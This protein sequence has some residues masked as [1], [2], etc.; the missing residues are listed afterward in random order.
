MKLLQ[1][2]LLLLAFFL[3]FGVHGFGQ[4]G[5]TAIH[6][7][8]SSTAS[9]STYTA[10]GA[11]NSPLAG[12]SYN[13]RY[14]SSSG[15][16]DNQL[17]LLSI[18]AASKAYRYESIPVVVNFRRVN[19]PGFTGVRDLM[20]YFGALDGSTLNLKAPYEDNMITAFE[21]NT[22]MLRGS[23]NLFA[24]AVDGNGNINNIERL[25]VVV[26]AGV[27]MTSASGQG[28]ALMERGALN[29][30]DAFVVGVITSI[31]GGG[32]PT[33][34]SSLIRVNSSH[35]GSVNVVPNQNSAVLRRDNGSGNLLVSTT[36]SGQGIGGVFFTFSDFGITDGQTVYGYSVA[37]SDF[38]VSGSP[39]DFVDYNNSIN[40]PLNTSGSNVG[41]ID[42]IAL[43]GLV[44]IIDLSGNVFHDDN[45]LTD[46]LVNGN[47]TDNAEGNQLYVN[48]I[49]SANL[50]VQSVLVQ[51]DGSF[52]F[53]GAPLGDLRLELST[54]QGIVG[55]APPLRQLPD[56]EWVYT[57]T[58]AG[59]GSVAT[60]NL[61]FSLVTVT[62]QDITDIRFGI[63]QKPTAGNAVAPII[64]HPGEGVHVTVDNNLFVTNDP[65]GQVVS[66]KLTAFPANCAELIVDGTVYTALTFPGSGIT[67]PADP[68][69]KPNV[70]ISVAPSAAASEM[71][72]YFVP[73]DNGG[74]ESNVAGTVTLPLDVSGVIIS[75]LYPATGPGTLAFEDLWPGKGDYDFNDLVIDYQFT[76]SSNLSNFV[77]QLSA[78][79]TIR[80]FGASFENGF[81]FQLPAIIAASDL[82][83]TGF[84]L[85]ENYVVLNANGTEEG[86]SKPTIIVYDNAFALMPHPG[87]GI[88]VNTEQDAPY[89]TPV[90][91]TIT[92][93][94]KPN[95]YTLNQLDISNFNP[96]LIVN[97]NRSH[98][99]H[100][101]GYPPTDLADL[102]L[103]GQ[104]E[105]SS[106]PATGKYYVTANNL[107]WAINIYESFDYPREKQEVVWA[108]LKFAEWAMS[109]GVL[110][111]DW[112]KNLSGYRNESFIYQRPNP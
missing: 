70:V 13:Y 71:I 22:N 33:T 24:N 48:L 49:N 69:G 8:T 73:I 41:G 74:Y 68:S 47:P 98:E 67:V 54:I 40:F 104:W 45:A 90:T 66:I 102:S 105:D 14:G 81:G 32:N 87:I 37:A 23:D 72:I 17:S 6:T 101:P 15:F 16:S 53:D 103:F 5:I 46:N 27:V 44:R 61:G 64:A 35:Y 7:V 62:D 89:V 10:N 86:Q 91:L 55:N 79:F 63:Q 108:H 52:S 3:I 57:G 43:T 42:M 77:S 19:N 92:I 65:D 110:F 30:H 84:N 4:S 96:F 58:T 82:T 109:G 29:Q 18:E 11:L 56:Q 106:D 12:N 83:V 38:P 50:V 60:G 95:T 88:G 93:L 28:F 21:G 39:G 36:L 20:F 34:Y 25:D 85:S 97:Q 75:N 1:R 112:Y 78:T 80:A 9:S 107:P 2:Y 100:L 59:N 94:F 99:V 51:N 111:P 76:I 26:P 31:D